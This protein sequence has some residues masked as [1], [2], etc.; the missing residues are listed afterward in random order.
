MQF[1]CSVF[2]GKY[3]LPS[4]EAMNTATARDLQQRT[5]RFSHL[6]G[7]EQFE[8]RD[9][10][11]SYSGSAKVDPAKAQLYFDAKK[12]RKAALGY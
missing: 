4:E 9:R 3:A 1:V 6:L 12:L 5:V 10:L 7:A 8:Y 2:S 11:A